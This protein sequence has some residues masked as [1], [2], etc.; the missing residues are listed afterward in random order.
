MG[1]AALDLCYVACGRFDA[2]FEYSLSPWDV[3]GGA[4]IV[5]EA[6]GKVT[7]FK[8]GDNW[9]FGQ[10]ILASNTH[11]HE[12]GLAVID[13]LIFAIGPFCGAFFRNEN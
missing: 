12:A 2:F 6:G 13:P 8:G 9:L 3:A 4:F 10:E 11:I 7:D 1:S 5:Q